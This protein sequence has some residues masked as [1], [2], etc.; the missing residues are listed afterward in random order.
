MVL[1][2]SF[3]ATQLKG[4]S[5][6]LPGVGLSCAGSENGKPVVFIHGWGGC[7]E[8]WDGTL[9]RCPAGF[10]FLSLDLPGTGGTES[11]SRYTIP[12]LAQWIHETTNRLGISSFTL[13][14]HSLGGNVAAC[15]AALAPDRVEKLVLVDA[16]LYS[17]R[18]Q[19]AR[20][21]LHPV[22]GHS[23]LVLTR[24]SAAALAAMGLVFPD[25]GRGGFWRPYFRRNKY[26]V[27]CNS[28]R[29]MKGQLEALVAH[30]FDMRLLP[31]A[32][33]VLIQHGKKDQVIP[34]AFA[35]EM[36]AT[37]P[38]NTILIGYENVM[39]CP[40]D[41]M[42]D[43]FIKDLADFLEGDPSGS[44]RSGEIDR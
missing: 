34:F 30:P 44:E 7:R 36:I 27:S 43:R 39:H 5:L 23:A 26:V 11:L 25:D 13:V 8:I 19:R 17:D 1:S 20:Y 14:G 31:P 6:A 41:A 10:R 9:A 28:H 37:R 40:M 16:A 2:R 3:K 32:L 29:A 21:C 38:I 22:T 4:P 12:L 15:A 42:P 18:I 24:V 33:P 35:E